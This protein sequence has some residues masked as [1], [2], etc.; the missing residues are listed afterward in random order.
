MSSTTI[1]LITGAVVFV[2]LMA[3]FYVFKAFNGPDGERYLRQRNQGP[4][5]P[6]DGD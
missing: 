6:R 1:W 4:F 5:V 3:L 2:S